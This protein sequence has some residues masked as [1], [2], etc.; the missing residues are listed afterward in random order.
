MKISFFRGDDHE[1]KFR[2]PNFNGTIE[3]IYLTVKCSEKTT[4]L[5]KKLG[6]GIELVDNYYVVTFV[7]DDTNNL[8][9][10]LKMTYD[11][12]IITGGKKYTVLKDEFEIEEDI[13]LP[14]DEV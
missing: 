2:F 14:K 13:T 8:P 3:M 10:Y 6:D 4:R 1:V 12:E 7:P 5:Q 9:C 11:I